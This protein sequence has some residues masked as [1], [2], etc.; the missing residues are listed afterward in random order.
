MKNVKKN[1]NYNTSQEY[2]NLE[3]EIAINIEDKNNRLI[4]EK[5][6]TKNNNKNTCILNLIHIKTVDYRLENAVSGTI[7]DDNICEEIN[8]LHNKSDGHF[9]MKI[10]KLY[11]VVQLQFQCIRKII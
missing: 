9:I 10:N 1:L 7:N 2:I 4:K 8:D 5:V 11:M 6:K 3:E